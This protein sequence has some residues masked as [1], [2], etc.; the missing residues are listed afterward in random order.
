MLSRLLPSYAHSFFRYEGSLT[1][2]PC[3]EFV[4]WSV[5]RNPADISRRQ[6]NVFREAARNNRRMTNNF[7]RTKPIK[8]RLVVEMFSGTA[9]PAATTAAA[10][11]AA[12]AALLAN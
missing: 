4:L 6:L 9:A 1:T 12:A 7:R 3:S 5:F 2:P 11:L 10:V 8:R